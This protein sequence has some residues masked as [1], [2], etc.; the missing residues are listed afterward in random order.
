MNLIEFD[1]YP[2]TNDFLKEYHM[3]LP[4]GIVVSAKCQTK[5]RGRRDH[6][7]E[8]DNTTL[9]MSVLLRRQTE[10]A[11][12][13]P[14]IASL[15]VCAALEKLVSAEAY[16]KW[17]NDILLQKDN[18]YFKVCGI[19]C[20]TAFLRTASYR[21]GNNESCSGKID[22]ICGIGV[23]VSTDESFFARNSLFFA[24]SLKL[25]VGFAPEIPVL[26]NAIYKEIMAAGT[27]FTP[28]MHEVYCRRC[29]TLGKDVSIIRA[30]NVVETARAIGISPDGELICENGRGEFVV[31]SGEVSIRMVR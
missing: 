22:V 2:S 4:P 12:F 18:S 25:T 10:Q 30:G 13:V 5:A 21:G 17:P 26:R 14:L 29:V 1:E 31:N 8:S 19:L 15:A 16:I 11:R 28:E 7:W 27:E 3:V 6:N 9:S 23:N 24:S 20:E